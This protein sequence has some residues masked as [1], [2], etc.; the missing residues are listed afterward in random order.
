MSYLEHLSELRN[1]LLIVAIIFIT[2]FIVGYLV[3]PKLLDFIR[4]YTFPSDVEWNVFTF[5]DGFMIYLKCSFLVAIFCTLPILIYQIWAFIKPGLTPKEAKSA[6]WYIPS[7]ILLFLLGLSFSFFILFP[8][9]LNFMS[10][11]NQN[12]GAT[13][14]YGIA[15]YFTLLFNIVFPVS[16]I[17]ELPVVVMFLSRIRILN[18][19]RLKRARKISYFI[20]VI[21]GVSLTP[22]DFVSDILIIV[23]LILLF[24]FSIQLS[25]WTIKRNNK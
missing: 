6:F 13:E 16:L 20:L 5:T 7:S 15:Q 23:P 12:L 25:S 9:V 11:L 14:T 2:S 8:M 3:S 18:P 22:P 10:S 24:E 19:T 4:Y 21:I 1:R 17:F